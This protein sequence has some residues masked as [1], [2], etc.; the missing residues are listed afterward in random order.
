MGH[1]LPFQP[2]LFTSRGH[3]RGEFGWESQM[4]TWWKGRQCS[5][6]HLGCSRRPRAC[7]M[8]PRPSAW[9]CTTQG[10]FLHREQPQMGETTEG[11]E[12]PNCSLRKGRHFPREVR[13]KAAGLPVC[14]TCAGCRSPLQPTLT[15]QLRKP[16]AESWACPLFQSQAGLPWHTKCR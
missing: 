1:V 3:S 13:P 9:L 4:G 6:R 16:H 12:V 5:T 2:H 14:R 15:S 7:N 10:I 8:P 11:P